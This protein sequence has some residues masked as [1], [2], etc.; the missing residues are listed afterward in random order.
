MVSYGVEKK[1]KEIEGGDWSGP[2]FGLY[3]L[4]Q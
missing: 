3:L 2:I 4:G 1:I